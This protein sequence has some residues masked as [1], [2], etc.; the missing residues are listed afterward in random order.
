[1][2]RFTTDRTVEFGGRVWVVR[3]SSSAQF[4]RDMRRIEPYL[5][6]LAGIVVDIL[7]FAVI[8]GSVRHR[9]KMRRAALRLAESR[10]E[11][12][13]L[14]ENVPGVVFRCAPRPPWRILHINKGILDLTGEPP[15]HF[16]E[17][18]HPLAEI[19]HPDDRPRI[20]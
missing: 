11:F 6:L 2:P 19:I 7:I 14:V 3:F 5:V 18:E 13:T 8:Y 15:E 12:R 20:E 4:E 10:D 17:G 16:I 1:M 9:R